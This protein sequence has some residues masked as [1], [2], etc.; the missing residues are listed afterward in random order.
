MKKFYVILSAM[1][2]SISSYTQ[3]NNQILLGENELIMNH[4]PA[5]T[6][7]PSN[8]VTPNNTP[9]WSSNFSNPGD[10][11]VDNTGSFTNEGWNIDATTDSWYLPAF[12]STSGGNFAELGNGDP[13]VAGWNGPMQVEY[14]LTTATP[15]NVFDSIGSSFATLSFE[16]FGARF[17]DLQ[18]VQVSTDG[19]NFVTVADNLSYTVT[20]QSAGSNPYPNPSLREISLA[21]YIGPTPTQV[22]IRFSWTTNYPNSATDPNVWITYGWCID[23]VQLTATPSYVMEVVDQNHGGWDI[24]YLNTTGVGMDYTFKPKN[25]SDANPY[26]FEMTI[27]NVGASALHG[28]QMN[29]EVVDGVGASVFSSSSD[30]TTLA[31]FDTAS[32]LANQTFAPLLQ[33]VYGMKFWA[34]SDSVL[35]SDT[36]FMTAVVTDSVY[37]RDNN[38]A[39]GAWRVGRTC[40]GLQLANKF[41]V[42]A[43]DE[44]TSVSA[45]VADYSVVGAEMYGVL[46]EVD[47]TGGSTS[48]I[49]LDQTNDY[50][51]Q[52]AD[53]DN[54]V[55]LGFNQANN[56]APGMYM[57]AIGGYVH[58]TD[59]FGINVSGAAEVTMSMIYDD[60][61]GCNLGS[62]PPPYWYWITDCPMIRLNFGEFSVNINE[63]T[64]NG[65]LSIYPNPSKGNFVLELK[66][67]ENDIYTLAITDILGKEVFVK[68][69][70][71]KGLAKEYIDLSTY[72]KGTYL[73]NLANSISTITK[74]LVVE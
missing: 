65:N 3:V 57:I 25:Q 44:A 46:Y 49:F 32:Y 50:T 66:G 37:G 5:I 7:F 70:D 6:P 59:T 45:Y 36:S 29:V 1:I 40:G 12:N 16:E 54:W 73:L 26:M 42:Y 41:D 38:N 20:S 4:L 53:R 10:W 43:A 23:D 60:G 35:A 72:S 61:Q 55:T 31:V 24:G 9:F 51:I 33:G 39:Q 19:V 62:Q 27:A 69:I 68:T 11:I 74:K 47:T 67:V 18:A 58:P 21:P 56:L 63:S 71:V 14:T 15:I 34:S 17:N 13:T 22:W 52:P 8:F 48:Y 64:F 2:F 30:T 28:I